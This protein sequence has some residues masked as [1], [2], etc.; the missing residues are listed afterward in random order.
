MVITKYLDLNVLYL[1]Q[2]LFIMPY[3]NWK[4]SY[5][6]DKQFFPIGQCLKGQN[7]KCFIPPLKLMVQLLF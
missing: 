5:N 2:E 6:F 3:I 7:I 4:D 1:N